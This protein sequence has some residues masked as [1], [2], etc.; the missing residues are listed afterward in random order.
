MAYGIFRLAKVKAGRVRGLLRH[1]NRDSQPPNADPDARADNVQLVGGATDTAM[2]ALADAKLAAIAAGQRWRKDATVAVDL[3]VGASPEVF[4]PGGS[5]FDQAAQDRY[6]KRALEWIEERF[7]KGNVLTA[8]VHR[9]ES[10]PHMQVILM[11][12][13]ERGH[14]N[15]KKVVGGPPEMLKIQDDFADRVLCDASFG[16]RRGERNS[17]ARHTSI[18]KF[19]AALNAAND[20]PKLV[21]VPARPTLQDRLL[22]RA[23]AIMAAR[24]AALK[25]NAETRKKIAE[26][27]AQAQAISPNRMEALAAQRRE[28]EAALAAAEASNIEASKARDDAQQRLAEARESESRAKRYAHSDAAA[29]AIAKLSRVVDRAAVREIADRLGVPG[30]KAGRDLIDQL[31]R[32]GKCSDVVSGAELLAATID[33]MTTADGDALAQIRAAARDLGQVDDAAPRP[34]R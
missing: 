8:Q 1:H 29:H 5:L 7:G 27:A 24:D 33:R 22:G 21:R 10:S 32:A 6:F 3:F 15:A 16:L 19:Y 18:R 11:P 34:E 30:L 26:I 12:R 20:L 31:R 9:D 23:D 4:R 28:I 17:K 25:R 2:G 14:F 13:D